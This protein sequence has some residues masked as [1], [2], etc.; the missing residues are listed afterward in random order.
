MILK[1]V[2]VSG[3]VGKQVYAR[4][5]TNVKLLGFTLTPSG[6]NATLKIRDGG[7][8]ASGD[9]VFFARA[10]SAQGSKEFFFDDGM[11]FTKGLHV[12]VVGTNAEG[13]LYLE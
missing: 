7:S 4:T 8:G 3:S 1:Q 10:T 9:V 13:Y 5:G 6:A 12:T 2:T 11:K